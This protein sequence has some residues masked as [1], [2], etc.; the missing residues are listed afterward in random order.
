M[1]Q[2]LEGQMNPCLSHD[3]EAWESEGGA[4]PPAIGS[5]VVLVN[6]TPNQVEWA[7]R[8]RDQVVADFDR[9]AISFRTVAGKQAPDKRAGT[10]AIIAILED[11]RA[12]VMREEHAGYFIREWQEIGDQV[13]QLILRDPRYQALK[14]SLPAND[15]AIQKKIGDV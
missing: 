10:E 3:V 9:V 4:A 14:S 15:F 12:A 2:S 6:G 7:E 5:S 1:A 13:R 11:K 8:I